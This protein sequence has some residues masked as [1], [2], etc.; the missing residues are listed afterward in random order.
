MDENHLFPAISTMM[1][2]LLG[3]R[4]ISFYP[5]AFLFFNNSAKKSPAAPID[6]FGGDFL[7]FTC[8]SALIGG[9][10]LTDGFLESDS[11]FAFS[12]SQN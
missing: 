1:L 3:F 9:G 7:N 10:G 2:A 6:S 8:F 11:I 5:T 4:G 12:C